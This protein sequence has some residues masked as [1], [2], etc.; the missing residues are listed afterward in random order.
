MERRQRYG[1]QTRCAG[2]LIGVAQ[3]QE[4]MADSEKHKNVATKV[5]KDEEIKESPTINSST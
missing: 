4:G 1:A 3:R 2:I 5:F